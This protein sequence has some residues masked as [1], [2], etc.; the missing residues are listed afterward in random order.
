MH[1]TFHH[2][3]GKGQHLR[4]CPN[5]PIIARTT[6]AGSKS[7]VPGASLM[8]LDPTVVRKT[9]RKRIPPRDGGVGHIAPERSESAQLPQGAM[10][11]LNAYAFPCRGKDSTLDRRHRATL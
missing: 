10:L 3:S 8:G 4:A 2:T 7:K 6:V 9:C 5:D 1:S 11:S